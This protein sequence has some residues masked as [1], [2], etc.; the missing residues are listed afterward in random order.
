MILSLAETVIVVGADNRPPMLD[1]TNYSLWESRMLLYIKGKEHG[2][3]LMDSVLNE[4]FQY[5][6]MVEPGNETTPT[7]IKARTYTDLTDEEKIRESVDIKTQ[8]NANNG[9]RNTATHHD[10][11]RQGDAGQA[12]VVKCY[13]YQEEGAYLDPE[14]LAFLVDNKDTVIPDQASQEIPTTTSF[15]TNDLDAFDSDCDDI[16]SAKST[17]TM[18]MLAKPQAF[19]DETHKTALGY[20]NPFYLSQAWRKVPALYDGNTIVKTQVALS[21]TDSEETIELAD[22]N[23]KY[24]KIE[25]KELSLDNDRL[26]EHIKCQDVMNTIMHANDHYD[27]MLPINNN[28]LKHDNY[29]LEL[30]K[31]ENNHL[32]ELLLSQDLVHTAVNSLATINDYKTMQQSFVDEY[33]ETLVLKAQ[34]AKKNDMIKK[35]FFIINE[36]PAQLKGKNISIEKLKEHI[37]NIKGKIMVESVQNVHN[38]NMVTLKVY[39]LDFPPLSPFIKNNMDAHVDYLKHT[40]ANADL[41]YKIVK[42]ARDLRPLDSNLASAGKFDVFFRNQLL[43]FQQHQD[44]SL[45]ASWTRFKDIIQK[46]PN[47]VLSIWTL[48]KIYLKHLDTLSYHI[49][50]LAAEGDLRKFSDIGACNP[51][52]QIVGDDIVRVQVPRCMAWLDYDEH[53]DSLSTMDNEVGVTNPESTTQTLPSFEEY[54]PLVT[55]PK[56]VEKTLKTLIEVETLN[57]TKLEEVGLNCNHNTPFSSKEVP[58]LDR[59]EPQPLLNSSSLDVSLGDIIGPKPP[60]KTYRPDS[61]RMKVVDYLTTQTPPSPHIA[62]SHPKGVYGY[63]N[64]G[65]DDP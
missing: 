53:V 7:T 52:A 20:Q 30:L 9:A 32:I 56:E 26:L 5:R 27:N 61:F 44:E 31:H 21:V 54:K 33:N 12:R 24:F 6:T 38:S 29:A 49:I 39:K 48:I 37:A 60:I 59:L 17:Q 57:K 41:L 4:P 11:Y 50:N 28:S 65:I 47:H 62:N 42:D 22:E 58:S 43:V 13:N 18:H 63:Y 10:V 36:L 3:L 64:P 51:N 46:V 14:Q 16:P 2:K 23:K 34:L 25:K 55:Y 35:E 1:K 15:Q 19:N 8:G 40:Q 45:Y